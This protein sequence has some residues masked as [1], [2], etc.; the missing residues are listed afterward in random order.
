MLNREKSQRPFESCFVPI[1]AF[2]LFGLI[3]PA[4]VSENRETL[5]V[6]ALSWPMP[7]FL[8]RG[9][10]HFLLS[11]V[12]RASVPIRILTVLLAIALFMSSAL[13]VDPMLS[14]GYSIV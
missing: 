12:H 3:F 8:L 11:S 9:R 2:W 1:V 7:I 5:Q 6:T 14:V 4:V 10:E 13:S